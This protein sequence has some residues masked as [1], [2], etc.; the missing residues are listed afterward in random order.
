[1][2]SSE[3]RYSARPG[4]CGDPALCRPPWI[5]ACAGMSGKY[6]E[7]G[8]ANNVRYRPATETQNPILRT[9][10]PTLPPGTRS[11]VALGL[12]AAAAYGR[13]KFQ[14]CEQC[15]AVQYPPRELCQA[16]LSHRLLW[17]IQDGSGELLTDTVLRAA[18]ELFF[19]ERLPWRVRSD[20]ARRRRECNRLSARARRRGTVPGAGRNCARPRRPGG[21][22]RGAGRGKA[23]FVRRSETA[24]IRLRSARAKNFGQRRQ[25]AGWP[26]RGAARS[27]M[28]APT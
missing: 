16:C 3:P 8:T 6:P 25:V 9:R 1:M 27:R 14:V 20:P 7:I 2:K 5:P 11:R 12:T 13:F 21:A 23:R 24:R 28:P 4:E 18:Q 10:L 19:R 22:D 15:G 17:R 26:G